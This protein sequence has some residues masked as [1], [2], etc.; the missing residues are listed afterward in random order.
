VHNY[1]RHNI[2]WRS[3]LNA[4]DPKTIVFDA[5][6]LIVFDTHVLIAQ[7][8]KDGPSGKTVSRSFQFNEVKQ[9]QILQMRKERI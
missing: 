6:V 8:G 2:V 5:R 1:V 9:K 4:I 3:N 7:G